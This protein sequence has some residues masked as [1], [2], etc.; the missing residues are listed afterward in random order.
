V[1]TL[2]EKLGNGT[3]KTAKPQNGGTAP[4]FALLAAVVLGTVVFGKFAQDLAK[5]IVCLDAY[6]RSAPKCSGLAKSE[7]LMLATMVST[8]V[9]VLGASYAGRWGR[10]TTKQTAVLVFG[11]LAAA[12]FSVLKASVGEHGFPQPDLLINPALVYFGCVV[13]L[14]A[15]WILVRLS[16]VSEE[17][18]LILAQRISLAVFLGGLLGALA[19]LMGEFVWHRPEDRG[20]VSKFVVAPVATVLGGAVFGIVMLDPWLRFGA[21]RLK[22]VV[23]WAALSLAL[24]GTHMAIYVSQKDW[25]EKASGPSWAIAALGMLVLTSG[26]LGVALACIVSTAARIRTGLL[27]AALVAASLAAAAGYWLG[28][29]RIDAKS[30]IPADLIAFTGFHALS[31]ILCIAAIFTADTLA[32]RIN[33][34]GLA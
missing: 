25:I 29:H 17:Q 31:P 5:W 23:S 7:A 3:T 4:T 13:V 11:A 1:A 28:Q 14:L 10:K 21:R 27:I 22:W 16:W 6:A 32:R 12:F 26:V 9:A 2:K 18:G 15:P 19:Q 20:S 24:A 30:M 33:R 34:P 8:F